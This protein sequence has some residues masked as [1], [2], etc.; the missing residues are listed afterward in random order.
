MEEVR[1]ITVHS[2]TNIDAPGFVVTPTGLVINGCPTLEEWIEFGVRLSC[3]EKAIHWAIGDWLFYG[4]HTYGELAA[5]G[6]DENRFRYQTLR[7]D[8]YVSSRIPLFRRRNKL[9]FGHH[10]AVASLGVDEQEQWL[11]KAESKSIP[12]GAGGE[13]FCT[14]CK[15]GAG[16]DPSMGCRAR[17]GAR[18]PD[19]ERS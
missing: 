5:Q 3:I 19:P 8:K 6:V 16:N 11:T 7:I 17:R 15:T 4:E 9:T 1:A 12:P 10:E 14:V 2:Q 18:P 13:C